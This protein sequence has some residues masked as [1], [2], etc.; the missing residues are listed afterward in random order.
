MTSHFVKYSFLQK[1]FQKQIEDLCKTYLYFYIP[2]SV[3][4]MFSE[5]VG[6]ARIDSACTGE[7]GL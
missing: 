4:K 2:F 7:M 1:M 5:K 6:K 3:Q